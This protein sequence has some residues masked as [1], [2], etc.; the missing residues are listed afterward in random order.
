MHCRRLSFFW[1]R[2]VVTE[3]ELVDASE[4]ITDDAELSDNDDDEIAEECSIKSYRDAISTLR[5]LQ[6]FAVQKNGP[7]ML[8][9]LVRVEDVA[10]KQSIRSL[11]NKVTYTI[12]LYV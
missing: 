4:L 10:E 1:R 2:D 8:A 11:S 12:T 3:H 9:A 7:D 5:K 6:K